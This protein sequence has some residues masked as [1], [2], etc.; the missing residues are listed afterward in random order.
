MHPAWSWQDGGDLLVSWTRRSRNGLDWNDYV[1]ALLGE[2]FERYLVG[3]EPDGLPENRQV[4]TVGSEELLLSGQTIDQF[5]LDGSDRILV[6]LQQLG[7]GGLSDPEIFT[8]A[9]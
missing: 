5:R 4:M 7:R 3:I 8:V 1:D 2:E 6:S 9:I